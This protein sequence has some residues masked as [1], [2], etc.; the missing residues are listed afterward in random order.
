MMVY[1]RHL[2]IMALNPRAELVRIKTDLLGYVGI[3]NEIE[4]S[5]EW[6]EVKREWIP[7][8]PSQLWDVSKL[9]RTNEYKHN[10][11]PWRNHRRE[12]LDNADIQSI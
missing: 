10:N 6:G 9:T 12:F 11:K 1:K 4:D 5:V 8:K 7:P 3:N 2:Q